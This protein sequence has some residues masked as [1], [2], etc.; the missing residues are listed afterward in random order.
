MRPKQKDICE[1]QCTVYFNYSVVLD[2]LIPCIDETVEEADT[3]PLL[4]IEYLTKLYL[5]RM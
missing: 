5:S 3:A 4:K 1:N 2:Q